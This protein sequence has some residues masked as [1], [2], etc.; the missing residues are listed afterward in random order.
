MSLLIL[1]TLLACPALALV[2][3]S[4]IVGPYVILVIF[5][6]ISLTTWGLYRHDKW[7]A[8][9]AH[10]RTP[11]AWLHFFE[12]IGGWPAAFLAQ[13]IFRHKISKLRY[14]ITFWMIIAIHQA[15]AFGF[16]KDWRYPTTSWQL[17]ENKQVDHEQESSEL[18]IVV[19]G[20]ITND[21][22]R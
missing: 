11:E 6:G 20:P 13:R 15:V 5:A 18:P 3:L 1:V 12:I 19:P 16:V 10:W 21:R 9:T 2:R 4:Q 17:L 8:E 14:Q 22:R 7:A